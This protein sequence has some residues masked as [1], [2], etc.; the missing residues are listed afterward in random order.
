MKAEFKQ[1]IKKIEQKKKLRNQYAEKEKKLIKEIDELLQKA[2]KM[3]DK[4][5]R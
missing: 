4:S 3:I 2:E 1:L 5:K